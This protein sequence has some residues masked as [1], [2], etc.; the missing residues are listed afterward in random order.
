MPFPNT[1]RVRFKKNPLVEVACQFTFLSAYTD[2]DGFN[3]EFMSNV[4]ELVK[5]RFPL[6][7]IGKKVSIEVKADQRSMDSSEIDVFEFSSLNQKEK[8]ALFPDSVVLLTSDY[9]GWEEFK[10]LLFYFVTEGLNNKLPLKRLS[11]VGL[12][13]KDIIQRSALGIPEVPWQELLNPT[14]ANFEQDKELSACLIGVNSKASLE[15]KDCGA[16]LNANYGVVTHQESLEKCFL[17]DSD[18]FLEGDIG[19]DDARKSLDTF[20]LKSRNFFQWCIKERLF[21]ALAPENI[22]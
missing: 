8:I 15:L 6:F 5:E 1:K 16:T 11:R 12:R 13:Y 7:N 17:I 9:Q 18:F 14:I 2:K 21:Q 20:N 22:S 4:H 10:D 3:A 19:Y